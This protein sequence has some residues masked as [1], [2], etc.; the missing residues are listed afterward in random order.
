MNK[1]I[2][3]DQKQEVKTERVKL[4]TINV[5][6]GIDL[7]VTEDWM[8]S[9]GDI[10]TY[11]AMTDEEGYVIED[12]ENF[13]MIHLRKNGKKL[14][15]VEITDEQFD[16]FNKAMFEVYMEAIQSRNDA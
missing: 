15:A 7:V 12:V 1:D 16:T 9:E 5:I 8:N 2:S 14:L 4:R 3:D 13:R 10:V 11:T 6:D